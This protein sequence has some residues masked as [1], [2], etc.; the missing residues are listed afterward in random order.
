[1]KIRTFREFDSIDD[2]DAIASLLP[3]EIVI[4]FTIDGGHR[5]AAHVYMTPDEARR[6][7]EN[8]LFYAHRLDPR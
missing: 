6:L 8:L 4:S 7:A 1:M 3:D 5:N 2:T